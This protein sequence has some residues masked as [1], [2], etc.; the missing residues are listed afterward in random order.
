MSPVQRGGIRGQETLEKRVVKIVERLVTDFGMDHITVTLKFD[1]KNDDD[2]R[3]ICEAIN[4]W[5]YR[6]VI[7]TW[8]LNLAVIMT[9]DELRDVAIHEL[10]HTM[11]SPLW[12]SLPTGQQNK[13][14]LVNVFA[15]EN[16]ARVI[17]HLV[18]RP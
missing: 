10:V 1:N 13:Y 4:E 16:V 17:S 12:D 11:I 18:E 8:H 6:Q 14:T 5:Q 7:L 3:C 2:A 15:T 9:D